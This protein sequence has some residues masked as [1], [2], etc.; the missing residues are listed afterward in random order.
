MLFL[1]H[2]FFLLSPEFAIDFRLFI[3]KNSQKVRAVTKF[4][5]VHWREIACAP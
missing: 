4:V 2:Y 5:A 1:N 3:L